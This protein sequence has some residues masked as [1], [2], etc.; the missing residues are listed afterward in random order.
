M[1]D[2]NDGGM[3]SDYGFWS[4]LLRNA[5]AFDNS[6]SS[7]H[8]LHSL[9]SCFTKGRGIHGKAGSDRLQYSPHPS[10]LNP[11]HSPFSAAL[12]KNPAL[13]DL[14][15]KAKLMNA[16]ETLLL[17]LIGHGS[18]VDGEFHLWITTGTGLAGEA[19]L[20]KPELEWAVADCKPRV[21]LITIAWQSGLLWNDA[22]WT[23]I[24]AAGLR[25]ALMRCQSWP[26]DS[27]EVAQ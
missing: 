16:G 9:Q 24:C 13:V 14:H 12:L 21:G 3:T 18:T 6:R 5:P 4:F 8:V 22:R 25:K 2:R 27:S 7:F 11:S 15:I 19:S 10:L 26:L 20:T 23:L 17:L 1:R